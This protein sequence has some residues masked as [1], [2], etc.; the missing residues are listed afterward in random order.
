MAVEKTNFHSYCSGKLH[1]GCELCVQGKKLVLFITGRCAQRCFYCPINEKKYGQD[2]VYANEWKIE[3]PKD[4]KELLEE[5]R[6]TRAC[7]AGITGGDPLM[8]L[9][10]CVDYITLLKKEFGKR[11]HIHLYTPLKL[12]SEQAL[13]RLH[14][15][16]LDEI[17]F[18]PDLDDDSLWP[19]LSLGRKFKWEVGVEI[20]VI[21]GYEAKT[22]KLIDFMAGKVDFLNLNELEVS[23][24]QAAH[25][26]LD[27]LGFIPK[28]DVS[29]GAKGSVELGLGL[30]EY[31]QSKGIDTHLCTAQLKDSVQVQMRIKRRAQ[32]VALPTD[33][34]TSEGLLIRGCVY[35]PGLAPGVSYRAKIAAADKTA[36]MKR[37]EEAAGKLKVSSGSTKFQIDD[38][39]LRLLTSK[40]A[41]KRLAKVIKK[42]GF[43]PAIV[44]EYPTRDGIE[45]DIE[46]L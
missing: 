24:T 21:P 4:P 27:R 9:D 46:F 12:V 38:F 6:L 26:S 18:H 42:A 3:D 16:G 15:A 32:G 19:R 11:F 33:I 20:P 44:E 2:V 29:Y 13:A 30:V 28:D 25:Y 23:D 37:L 10:R 22:K 41:V 31:A 17:R 34:K 35:L 36:T 5:A 43:I 45:M 8:D 1:K 39:K 7:G 40:D 14:Q